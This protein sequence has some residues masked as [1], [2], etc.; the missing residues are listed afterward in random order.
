MDTFLKNMLIKSVLFVLLLLSNAACS[1]SEG[2]QA[3]VIVEP[4]VE[5]PIVINDPITPISDEDALDLVQK[6]P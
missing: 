5:E 1:N 4:I 3:P 2:Y 6:Q